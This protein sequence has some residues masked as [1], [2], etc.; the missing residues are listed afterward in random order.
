MTDDYDMNYHHRR[1]DSS[2]S[3]DEHDSLVASSL[4][5]G[6]IC[7]QLLGGYLGDVIGRRRAMMVVMVLQIVGSLGGAFIST[8]GA[9]T[10]TTTT[11][12]ADDDIVAGGDVHWNALN[13]L[14]VWRFVLGVGAGGVYPLAAVMSV[15]DKVTNHDDDDDDDDGGGGRQRQVQHEELASNDN[16]S[17][18][19]DL[20]HYSHDA[21]ITQQE[22]SDA[23]SFQR[24]ALTFSMQGLGF[25]TVPLLA[26]PM[27]AILHMDTN[28]VW[29]LL[30]GL[31]ALPGF[32]V[33]YLRLMQQRRK[34]LI[35]NIDDDVC[36]DDDDDDDDAIPAA[37]SFDEKDDRM[38]SGGGSL[39]LTQPTTDEEEEV[40]QQLGNN[41][42]NGQRETTFQSTVSTLFN[43]IVEGDPSL[44]INED[45][46][47]SLI[48]DDDTEEND[49]QYE[50]FNDPPGGFMLEHEPP[51]PNMKRKTSLWASLKDEPNLPRKLAGT[52]GTWFLFDLIFYGNTLFEPVVL[53]AAFGSKDDVEDGYTL[54]L[55]AVRDSLLIS[56]LSLPGYFFT[57]MLIG[58]RTCVCRSIRSHSSSTRCST[59][60]SPVEQSPAF[61]QMQGFCI[62]FI[63]YLIIGLYWTSLSDIQWLLLVLYASSFFFANYGPNS[64][65]FLLPSVTYSEDC[66]S[67]LNGIS[68]AAGKLGAL[69]GA[70]AFEPAANAWGESTV[71]IVCGVVSLLG[72]GLTKLCVGKRKEE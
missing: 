47:I 2:S 21:I 68:A 45:H 44:H 4:L 52:A 69:V 43:D 51:L 71:M 7:G 11:A 48:A 12:A 65:T 8:D 6:M 58:R 55:M 16:E 23:A 49:E 19:A 46:Q 41:S 10:T 25:I 64:T 30:L 54:L 40:Q 32:I 17:Q 33:M 42:S 60:F 66:R 14:A 5:A 36:D 18:Y 61:I 39:E 26:Y 56:L 70:S 34:Q 31:G 59:L 20:D 62:M 15:E 3:S 72:C 28:I 27:L 29:R 57:V 22:K 38:M 63:L 1:E 37:A 53:E 35:E 13:Q 67:T 24:V 50:G 9:S